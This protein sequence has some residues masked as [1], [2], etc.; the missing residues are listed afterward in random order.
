MGFWYHRTSVTRQGRLRFNTLKFYAFLVRPQFFA[1]LS[2]RTGHLGTMA[3]FASRWAL[4]C[5]FGNLTVGCEL[6]PE[7]PTPALC[8]AGAQ[9]LEVKIESPNGKRGRTISLLKTFVD[10]ERFCLACA[11]QQAH[12]LC[13][14]SLEF[15]EHWQ[16]GSDGGMNGFY[17][18][19]NTGQKIQILHAY[20]SRLPHESTRRPRASNLCS[21]WVH[22]C[23]SREVG[24]TSPPFVN[25]GNKLSKHILTLSLGMIPSYVTSI[26]M[27]CD[28]QSRKRE[29]SSSDHSL[30]V[31][32]AGSKRSRSRLSSVIC[33]R[34]L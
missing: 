29:R 5:R 26:W 10:R 4:R 30:G 31:E 21:S 6:R 20:T 3:R 22:N 18:S 14:P 17:L 2:F 33:L 25:S 12:F 15:A 11:Y 32:S 7:N 24:S 23:D 8:I 27:E 34:C 9:G 13:D 28:V 16:R 19:P 1:Y